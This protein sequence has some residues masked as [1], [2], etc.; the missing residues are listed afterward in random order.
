MF[1]EQYVCIILPVHIL[2]EPS[3]FIDIILCLALLFFM[4][5]SHLAGL[6]VGPMD[7]ILV[8]MVISCILVMFVFW[9]CILVV[10]FGKYNPFLTIP[11]LGQCAMHS[12][13]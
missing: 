10:Y 11:L 5:I 2:F 1:E 6:C 4:E 3:R 8:T 7:R 13:L 12:L 9:C